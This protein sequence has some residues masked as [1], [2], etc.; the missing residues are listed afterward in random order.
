MKPKIW[1]NGRFVEE[2][3]ARVPVF[4]RG[5]MYGDGV[6]ETMRS[7][8]GVV[9]KLDEHIGRLFASMSVLGIKPP[10]SRAY[11]KWAL[12][13]ALKVNRIK[14]AYIKVVVTRGQGRFGIGHRDKFCPNAVIVAK[15]FEGYP[16]WM[17]EKGITATVA[18]LRQNEQSVLSRVKSLNF[19]GYILARLEAKDRGY[20][21]A[22][23]ANTRGHIAEAA[24][25]NV[26]LTKNGRIITP[27]LMSGILPGIARAT[28]IGIAGR[29]GIPVRERAVSRADLLGAD[30]V[31]L[32]NSLA[33]VLPVRR[34]GSRRIGRACPGAITKLLRI[35]YQKEVIRAV[36]R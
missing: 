4:D 23:L 24:T 19:L 28:V 25:S 2:G 26:F 1:L 27:S 17:F 6:F 3:R 30:E 7:Y 15:E 35:S 34:V 5:F 14:C 29:L 22:I 12:Y 10:F 36:L 13:R 8:A 9:F 11:I 20:D 16:E 18:G 33:E 21:E 31:F 32:T